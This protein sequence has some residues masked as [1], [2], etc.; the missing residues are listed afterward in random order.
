MSGPAVATT[1]GTGPAAQRASVA[2]GARV[3]VVVPGSLDDGLIGTVVAIEPT[4]AGGLA[5]PWPWWVEVA[6]VRDG[7]RYRLRLGRDE[8]VP[9]PDQ[10]DA[11]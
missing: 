4:F 5:N 8:I 7:G 2:V 6:G 1:D 10:R 3:R 11:S 9:C